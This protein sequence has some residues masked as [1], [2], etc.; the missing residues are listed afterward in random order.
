MKQ[1]F[2]F[3]LILTIILSQKAL[4]QQQMLPIG[5]SYKQQISFEINKND[6]AINTGFKPLL[7]SDVNNI[8]NIDSV[9]YNYKQRTEFFK[10]HKENWFLRALFFDDFVSLKKKNFNLYINPLL[11]VE[12]GK[13]TES[14]ENYYINTRAIEIKG[15]IGKKLSFYSSFRENQAKFRPYIYDW[16]WNRLVVPGQGAMKKNNNDLSLYDFSSASA[17]LSLSPAKWLNIQFGQ[18]KNFIGEGHRSLL[19]S[20]NAL[21]YP[22]AKFSFTY[23]SFKYV[24]MFTEFRDFETAYYS[25]HYKKHGVFNYFSYNYKNR[26]EVGFFEGAIYQTT[27]TAANYYNKFK[28]DYFIP[29]I[30]IR[31]A[32]NGFAS[33]NNILAGINAKVK[34]T[35][36]IQTYGQI[37]I[38]NP[39]LKKFAYQGGIKIFDI[40]HEKIKNHKIYFQAEYNLAKPRTYSHAN[41]KYQTWTHYKQELAHP[42]GSDFKEMFFNIHYSYKSL[43]LD[44]NYTNLTLNNKS[45]FSDIYMLDNYT[46]FINPVPEQIMHKNLTIA[47]IINPRTNLQIYGGFD[48]REKQT[49]NNIEKSSYIMF[50]I[51]TGLNNFYYD[52]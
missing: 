31:T 30:G 38:D 33:E 40:L 48:F 45:T 36:Y 41:L 34:I 44:F 11:Y 18:D 7:K 52:F 35:D 21:N 46:Y 28:S 13:I 14:G 2:F 47:Y 26:F 1:F 3:I 42:A 10:N 32:I 15:D 25:Y 37:A 51:K 39:S 20:D 49:E 8:T 19:L 16:A 6:V 17:Y 24:T 50:G 29:V 9:I 27:D 22:F 23:K 4:S 43:L 5:T 12:A